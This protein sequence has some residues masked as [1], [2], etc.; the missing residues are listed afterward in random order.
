VEDDPSLT[1][2][3]GFP[4]SSADHPPSSSVNGRLMSR[5][6]EAVRMVNPGRGKICS[7]QPIRIDPDVQNLLS[8]EEASR[9]LHHGS[10]DQRV[11]EDEPAG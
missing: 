3:P 2:P 11:P 10:A 6:P 4:S 7:G 5:A 9:G 1:L 8:R